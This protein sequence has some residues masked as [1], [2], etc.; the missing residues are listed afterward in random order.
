[1][2]TFL[3]PRDYEEYLA[4]TERPPVHLLRILAAVKMRTRFVETTPISNKQVSLFDSQ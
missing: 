3:E 1:M 2:T 4:P